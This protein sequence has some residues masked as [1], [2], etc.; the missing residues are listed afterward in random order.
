MYGERIWSRKKRRSRSAFERSS[1]LSS[2]SGQDENLTSGL[3][4]TCSGNHRSQNLSGFTADLEREQENS[5][6][7]LCESDLNIDKITGRLPKPTD[8]ANPRQEW[9]YDTSEVTKKILRA[10]S[11]NQSIK[12][13]MYLSLDDV[14][15]SQASRSVRNLIRQI[16]IFATPT[17]SHNNM[18]FP[19]TATQTFEVQSPHRSSSHT[20]FINMKNELNSCR[21]GNL[22]K[23]ITVSSNCHRIN[24]FTMHVPERKFFSPPRLN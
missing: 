8:C 21:T 23:K 17:L 10:Q 19:P 9:E 24:T 18:Y 6:N 20:Q 7:S 15:A 3:P 11:K 12:S 2:N 1:R 13:H 4:L 14:M 16:R 5:T 22:S